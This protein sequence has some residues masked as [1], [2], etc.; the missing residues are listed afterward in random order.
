MID[1][2]HFV[3]L[4]SA[5]YLLSPREVDRVKSDEF[6]RKARVESFSRRSQSFDT[7]HFE[8][9]TSGASNLNLRIKSGKLQAGRDLD[10]FHDES[11][12]QVA[13]VSRRIKGI[14]RDL[15]MPH[16]A[17]A[18]K[19]ESVLMDIWR[20]KIAWDFLYPVDGSIVKG[21]YEKIK[22][23]IC[24]ADIREKTAR[25]QYVTVR[26]FLEDL[27]LMVKNA[28]SYNGPDSPIAKNAESIYKFALDAVEHERKLLGAH[29]DTFAILEDAIIDKFDYLNRSLPGRKG[30]SPSHASSMPAV[31]N[32]MMTSEHVQVTSVATVTK[33]TIDH[34]DSEPG[35]GQVKVNTAP[36]SED[37]SSGEEEVLEEG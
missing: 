13:L 15:R 7:E 10:D 29:K 21:Y 2:P 37:S 3:F 5:E 11:I 33:A 9:Y 16:I 6:K 31:N 27:H 1:T 34:D 12:E 26:A 32:V 17:F 4:P 35:A 23:P 14:T 36:A 25:C 20:L 22:N 18:V 30:S 8:D 19:I 28:I 24:L